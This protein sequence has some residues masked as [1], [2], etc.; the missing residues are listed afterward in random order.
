MCILDEEAGGSVID[1]GCSPPLS[2]LFLQP[3]QVN[4]IQGFRRPVLPMPTRSKDTQT[5]EW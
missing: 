5:P 2:I 1:G 4:A 3:L